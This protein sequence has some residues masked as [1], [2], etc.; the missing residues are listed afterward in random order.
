[1]IMMN[2]KIVMGVFLFVLLMIIVPLLQIFLFSAHTAGKIE[3]NQRINAP[4]LEDSDKELML[5]FY[6]YV[7]CVK[8]CTPILQKLD[9]FYDSKEFVPYKRSVGLNFVNL[10]PELESHQPDSFAKSFNPQFIGRYLS[11]KELMNIDRSLGVFFSKNLSQ[12][13]E[14]NHSDNLYLIQREKNGT[15]ILKSIY[16]MHPLNHE[17]LVHDISVLQEEK[18]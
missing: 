14:I 3:I 1:M 15:L 18:E 12:P 13:D 6:G 8:V 16:T 10:M 7:G 17:L 4:Y 5:V 2:K 11:Q 9:D